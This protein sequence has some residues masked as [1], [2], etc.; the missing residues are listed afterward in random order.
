MVNYIP[1]QKDI[2]YVN[3]NPI[4]GHE[5]SVYRLGVVISNDIFNIIYLY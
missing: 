3:F 2:V 4:K 1:K 5:Q